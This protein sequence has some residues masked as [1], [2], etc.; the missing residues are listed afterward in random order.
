[1][2]SK[3]SQ[4]VSEEPRGVLTINQ[5]KAAIECSWSRIE[6]PKE[7]K[8]EVRFVTQL[9]NFKDW[10]LPVSTGVCHLHDFHQFWFYRDSA[11]IC[12]MQ[13]KRFAEDTWI[14]D[15]IQVCILNIW[16]VQNVL[17]KVVMFP[18]VLYVHMYTFICKGHIG[19]LLKKP[20]F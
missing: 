8:P 5:L 17:K 16:S 14:P 7:I 3:V 9:Y 2:F 11:N 1:M 4:R 10:L 6:G 12:Q 18:Y 13:F 15:L 20:E 19:Y